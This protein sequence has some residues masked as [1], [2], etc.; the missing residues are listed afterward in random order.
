[1]GLKLAADDLAGGSGK[2]R[3]VCQIVSTLE[4]KRPAFLDVISLCL[5]STKGSV[6]WRTSRHP[7]RKGL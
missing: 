4:K 2:G 6:S 5:H 7:E 3:F 1:M